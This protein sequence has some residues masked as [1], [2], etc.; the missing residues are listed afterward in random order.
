MSH[1]LPSWFIDKTNQRRA[2]KRE[3]QLRRLREYMSKV[4]NIGGFDVQKISELTQVASII[5]DELVSADVPYDRKLFIDW[6]EDR[7]WWKGISRVGHSS[8]YGW[9]ITETYPPCGTYDSGQVVGC[10][11]VGV[12]LTPNGLVSYIGEEDTN[13]RTVF[14]FGDTRSD[15]LIVPSEDLVARGYKT[16]Y[17]PKDVEDGLVRLHVDATERC[18]QAI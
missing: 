6:T 10:G 18:E 17:T 11:I 12:M 7:H 16:I 9:S 3:E 4:E 5:R 8:I 2:K 13:E 1:E 14:V 15:L